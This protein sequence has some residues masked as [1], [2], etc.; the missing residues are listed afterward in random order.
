MFSALTCD[1]SLY[2]G[3]NLLEPSLAIPSKIILVT[4]RII[5]WYLNFFGI[6]SHWQHDIDNDI[7]I[8]NL[9]M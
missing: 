2:D 7:Y 4:G 9:S 6:F 5:A 3:K 1:D 8:D